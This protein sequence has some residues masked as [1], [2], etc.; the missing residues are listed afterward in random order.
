M[1][2]AKCI[3]LT[4]MTIAVSGN[5]A[6]LVFGVLPEPLKITLEKFGK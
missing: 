2:G 1:L 5:F 6:S 3:V 4:T